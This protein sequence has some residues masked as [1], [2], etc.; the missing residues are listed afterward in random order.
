MAI[1]APP[2]G[3]EPAVQATLLTL[4]QAAQS[5]RKVW[6]SYRDGADQVTQRTLRPLGCFYWGKVWT[7]AAWC[8]TRND[9][10]SFR[11]DRM[12]EVQVLEGAA[13]QFRAESGKALADYLREAGCPTSGAG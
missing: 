10:R 1:Y 7:L 11:L 13:G 5:Q 8:E 2:M 12:H 4:R 6:V 9:F 3:L